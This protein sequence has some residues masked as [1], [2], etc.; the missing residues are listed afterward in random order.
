MV[1]VMK[2]AR[3]RESPVAM[4]SAGASREMVTDFCAGLGGGETNLCT[5]FE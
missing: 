3:G 5:Q 4:G 2:D 1:L